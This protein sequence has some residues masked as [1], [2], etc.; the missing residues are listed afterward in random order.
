MTIE[1]NDSGELRR[2]GE[3]ARWSHRDKM[4]LVETLDLP[5]NPYCQVFIPCP[6]GAGP[7]PFLP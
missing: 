4:E 3:K 1:Q 5:S 7:R 2:G 6:W